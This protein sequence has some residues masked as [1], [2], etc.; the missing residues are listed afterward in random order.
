MGYGLLRP[1]AAIGLKWQVAL[2]SA[3]LLVCCLFCHGE[4]V[5]RKPPA[6]NLTLFYLNVAAGGVLGGL[7]VGVAGPGLF[8]QFLELPVGVAAC[9]I[10]GMSLLYH[11]PLRRV[12][13]LAVVGAAGLLL[14][15]ELNDAQLHTRARH[16]NFYGALQVSELATGD[17]TLR[18]LS[19]GTVQ[20]GSQFG[21]DIKGRR[22]TAYYGELSGAALA[23][24]SMGER[25]LRVALIGLG[26]GALA[27]YARPGDDY[28]FYE[29]N[30]AVI[31]FARREFR[32]LGEARGRMEVEAG[33]G[34]LVLS[35]ERSAPY[36]AV[37]VDAFSGDSI[38]VH[39]LTREAFT[40]YFG[41]LTADG[42]VAVHITNR[43]VD[44]EGV[45]RGAAEEAGR[46]ALVVRS[47]GNAEDATHDAVW[48][49]VTRNARVIEDLRKWGRD[50]DCPPRVWTDDYSDLFSVLR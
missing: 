9:V 43:Y 45:V 47:S 7:F 42:V 39:L 5:R 30:P 31:A 17:T 24:R 20:H 23:L 25:P 37:V 19:S 6:G 27:V 12:A 49:V 14:A 35:H 48:M 2:F 46:K 26:A 8:N 34:R 50:P 10:L 21:D 4:L 13:R 11:L 41:H 3:A 16:R 32:Y 1:S 33:D 28:C 22:A 29:L 44:L 36:D 18:V 40:T 38:P 15:S